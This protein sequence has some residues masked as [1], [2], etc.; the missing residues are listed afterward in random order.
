MQAA[1][2][3]PA[4]SAGPVSLWGRL[5]ITAKNL[6]AVAV[7]AAADGRVRH[8]ATVERC[9]GSLL[10][11]ANEPAIADQGPCPHVIAADIDRTH[12]DSGVAAVG[13]SA[14]PQ[15]LLDAFE[16]ILS[17]QFLSR[18]RSELVRSRVARGDR[19]VL[20]LRVP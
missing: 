19:D 14:C 20:V 15:G 9:V 6:G 4:G 16:E 17:R 1:Q 7:I 11:A 3:N 10:V 8:A 5:D 13:E 12:T 2:A 18:R